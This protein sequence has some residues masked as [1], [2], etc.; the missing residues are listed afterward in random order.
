MPVLNRIGDVQPPPLPASIERTRGNPWR[1]NEADADHENNDEMSVCLDGDGV[2]S[3]FEGDRSAEI[4]LGTGREVEPLSAPSPVVRFVTA[5]GVGV[6]TRRASEWRNTVLIPRNTPVPAAASKRFLTTAEGDRGT[7]V[8][9]EITQ[10]DTPD[11]ELAEILGQGRIEGFP[12][13]ESPGRA[14]EVIME[15]D[16]FGRLHVRAVYEP[17][18]Q[19]VELSLDMAGCLEQ[20]EVDRFRRELQGATILSVFDPDAALAGL[21]DDFDDDDD[22]FDSFSASS[23]GLLPDN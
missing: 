15:F 4:S 13:H 21:D 16:A 12:K 6:K 1:T 9:I 18:G 8:N 11:I 5:H 3:E 22:H 17:T 20:E 7:H 19:G 10:G 23:G 14:V 2:E